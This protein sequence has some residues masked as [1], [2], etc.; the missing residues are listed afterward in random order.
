MTVLARL[1]LVVMGSFLGAAAGVDEQS[2]VTSG[3]RRLDARRARRLATS[4][5]GEDLVLDGLTT[6]SVAEA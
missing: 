6:L 4:F 2:Q 5:Q 3:I 1:I